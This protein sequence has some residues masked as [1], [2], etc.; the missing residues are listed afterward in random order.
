LGEASKNGPPSTFGGVSTSDSEECRPYCL[1]VELSN[2][3]EMSKFAAAAAGA[4]FA[5]T[6]GNLT[7]QDYSS[8]KI[9]LK[10]FQRYQ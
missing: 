8:K 6:G 5:A 2:I 1:D 9:I 7:Q 4:S 3:G 10:C